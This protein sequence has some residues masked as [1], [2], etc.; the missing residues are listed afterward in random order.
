VLFLAFLLF[1][2]AAVDALLARPGAIMTQRQAMLHPASASVA[3]TLC[4]H[5]PALVA[6]SSAVTMKFNMEKFKAV[7]ATVLERTA[8]IASYIFAFTEISTSFAVKVFL[9]VDSPAMK[10]FYA[11]FV[12]KLVN[13]YIQNVYLIF[14]L[15]IGIFIAASRGNM[16]G[17]KFARFN[18]IQAI[19]LNII[20]SCVSAVFPLMP[21]VI[22][23]SAVGLLLAN[24]MYLGTCA[25]IVYSSVLIAFGRYPKIPVLSEGARLQVQRG[26]S[27]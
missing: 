20:C 17:S 15:M 9:N 10:F 8:C 14:A 12:A 22:R 18:I 4:P 26:Y 5:C 13:L 27:D 3:R 1:D 6:R 19:L 2:H 21:L 16:G 7:G 23:E 11:N 25:L 24:F